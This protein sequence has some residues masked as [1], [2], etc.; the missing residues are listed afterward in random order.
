MN[1]I[2]CCNTLD[3]LEFSGSKIITMDVFAS[4]V[5]QVAMQTILYS[6]YYYNCILLLLLTLSMCMTSIANFKELAP[7][8]QELSNQNS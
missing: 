6:S 3:N 1:Q 5:V 7:V 2:G 4:Y 8:A